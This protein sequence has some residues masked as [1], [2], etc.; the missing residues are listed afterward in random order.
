VLEEV[1]EPGGAAEVLDHGESAEPGAFR[2]GPVVCG[3][4]DV[5]AEV[6]QFDKQVGLAAGDGG[7]FAVF[8]E[9]AA[10]V[11]VGLRGEG[12]PGSACDLDRHKW[13]MVPV[14]CLED[15]DDVGADAGRHYG[16]DLR[17]VGDRCGYLVD[18]QPHVGFGCPPG[19]FPQVWAGFRCDFEPVVDQDAPAVLVHPVQH[20]SG[21]VDGTI[22]HGGSGDQRQ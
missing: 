5:S 11:E 8:G 15:V 6:E 18:H 3:G 17:C 20:L 7:V 14:C 1:H 22:D 19:Q 21:L 4:V 9:L 12:S 2:T 10:P 13:L 16:V